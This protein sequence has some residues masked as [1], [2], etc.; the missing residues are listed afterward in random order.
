MA[1]ILI[2]PNSTEAMT[3]SA[4]AAARAA[5]PELQFEGWTSHDAP[6]AIEGPEDGDR[7]IPALLDLVRAASAGGAR[8]IIIA[9][10]DDTGL[11]EARAIAACPVIGIGQSSFVMASLIAESAAVVTTVEAA[12]PVIR[13]NIERHGLAGRITQVRA[14]RVPVLDLETAP[15]RAAQRFIEAARALAPEPA[16]IILGCAGAVSISR[17]V[18]EA[19]RRPVIEG[20]SSAARLCRALVD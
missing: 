6:P 1:I 20:V 14:A 13:S 10:Y 7:A 4:L 19:M 15:D 2:N 11:D 18:A 3:R 9:C 12:V 8:A 16:L 5:A 17:Q